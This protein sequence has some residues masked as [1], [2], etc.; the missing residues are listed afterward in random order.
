MNLHI[1]ANTL[2]LALV[3][4]VTAFNNYS[5]NQAVKAGVKRDKALER[6]EV[7]GEKTHALSNGSLAASLARN[8]ASSKSAAI[9]LWAMAKVTNDESSIAAA[10]AADIVA[11]DAEAALAAHTQVEHR[12]NPPGTLVLGS[13]GDEE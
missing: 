7:T 13:S 1:D 12:S 11:A 2:L 3:A 4:V 8:V 5:A 6:I 10:K 9:A